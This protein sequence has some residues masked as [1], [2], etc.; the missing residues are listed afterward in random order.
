M[1]SRGFETMDSLVVSY[2]DPDRKYEPPIR[3]TPNRR[4]REQELGF[5]HDMYKVARLLACTFYFI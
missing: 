4:L 3:F 5:A 1:G 2:H